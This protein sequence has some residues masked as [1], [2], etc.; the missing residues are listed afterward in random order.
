MVF[1]ILTAS[2]LFFFQIKFRITSV[3]VKKKFAATLIELIFKLYVIL[4][5]IEIVACLVGM[6]LNLVYLGQGSFCKL[7]NFTF[8]GG[9][10]KKRLFLYPHTFSG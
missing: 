6:P 7:Y 8:T 9:G 3:K 1:K 5:E 4:E 2:L 10:K